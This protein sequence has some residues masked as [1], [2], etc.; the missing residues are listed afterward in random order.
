[1]MPATLPLTLYRGDTARWQFK[2]WA[3]TDKTDPVDLQ[4]VTPKAEIR[5]KPSGTKISELDC[6]V[7]LPNI[8][9][10]S[11]SPAGSRALPAKGYWDLQL[12]YS[13]GDIATVL[14]GGVTVTPDITDSTP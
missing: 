3:D 13:S 4:D 12:T 7:E 14:A 8:I 6:E 1:M 9:N 2:L 11:L 10:M 5:D